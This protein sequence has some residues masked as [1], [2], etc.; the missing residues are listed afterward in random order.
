MKRI[1]ILLFALLALISSCDK[2]EDDDTSDRDDF[3]GT[4]NMTYFLD[5]G[6][7]QHNVSFTMSVAAISGAE[8]SIVLSSSKFLGN[9]RGLVSQNS[10]VAEY[11]PN[12]SEICTMNGS[13]NGNTI[14]I[15]LGGCKLNFEYANNYCF[16]QASDFTGTK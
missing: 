13:L 3:V 16:G 11:K 4:Y 15:D 8:D 5:C 10:F 2:N 12:S 9:Y 7:E 14:S 1:T 6:T